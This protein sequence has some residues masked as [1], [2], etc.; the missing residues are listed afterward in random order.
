M[1]KVA[2]LATTAAAR[3]TMNTT[4]IV[5]SFSALYADLRNPSYLRSDTEL[6]SVA[7]DRNRFH[8]AGAEGEVAT[9]KLRGELTEKYLG[10][11]GKGE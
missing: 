1:M 7:D 8:P 2:P 11:A 9:R 5:S 10:E 6:L 3:V 4:S